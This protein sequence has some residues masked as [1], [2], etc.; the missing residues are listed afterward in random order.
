MRV[1]EMTEEMTEELKIFREF[2]FNLDE[3]LHKNAIIDTT[4]IVVLYVQEPEET[5]DG[6][7]AKGVVQLWSAYYP[8][9]A[10]LDTELN[11]VELESKAFYFSL[12]LEDVRKFLEEIH[13]GGDSDE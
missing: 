13:G 10:S 3:F 1:R 9:K 12:R 5:V 2:L 7:M 8:F 11:T 6:Y 4:K